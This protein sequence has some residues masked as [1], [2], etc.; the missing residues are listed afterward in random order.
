M[1]AVLSLL[2]LVLFAAWAAGALWLVAATLAALAEGEGGW[3]LVLLFV[4]V[5]WIGAPFALANG[6]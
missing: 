5:V 1:S 3:F 6:Q 2:A 4:A